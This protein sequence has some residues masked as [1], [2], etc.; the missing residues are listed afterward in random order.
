MND[1]H[2]LNAATLGVWWVGAMLGRVRALLSLERQHGISRGVG[3]EFGQSVGRVKVGDTF[4]WRGIGFCRRMM[5][6]SLEHFWIYS[7]T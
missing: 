1:A 5:H 3:F 6:H 2:G 4:Y 7:Y